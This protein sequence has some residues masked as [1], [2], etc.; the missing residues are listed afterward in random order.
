MKIYLDLCVYNRPFDDQTQPRI[1]LETMALIFLLEKV[2]AK[3]IDLVGSFALKYENRLNPFGER[4]KKINDILTE[5]NDYIEY[6]QKIERRASFLEKIGLP[7]MD[8][9]HIASAEAARCS[10]FVTCDD[11]LVKKSQAVK[12]KLKIKIRLLLD[13]VNKEI[14]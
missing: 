10:Y 3:E 1:V 2:G 13:F 14:F 12:E 7:A 8:A 4:R 6:S 11:I 9:I 5:A